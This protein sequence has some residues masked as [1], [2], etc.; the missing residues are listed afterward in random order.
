MAFGFP[1]ALALSSLALCASG[2]LAGPAPCRRIA[3]D[4]FAARLEALRIL[5][6]RHFRF[7]G[8]HIARA[9]GRASCRTAQGGP[10]C[11]FSDP[12]AVQV[13]TGRGRFDFLPGPGAASIT[14]RNGEVGCTARG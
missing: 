4:E 5:P 10:T 6:G 9:S 8:A 2:A 3:P 1:R 14:V 11:R 12:V 7:G 13:T